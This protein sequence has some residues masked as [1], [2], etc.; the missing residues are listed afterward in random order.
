VSNSEDQNINNFGGGDS[1]SAGGSI[2]SGGGADF[3]TEPGASGGFKTEY[4]NIAPNETLGMD[5]VNATFKRFNDPSK[6]RFIKSSFEVIKGHE[7]LDLIDLSTFFHPLQSFSDIEKQTMV[8]GSMT[9]V[10][11]SPSSFGNT[12]GEVSL[13]IARAYYLPESELDERVLFWDYLG[14]QRNIM[15]KFMVLTGAVK[16]GYVWKGWDVDP[17]LTYN[18]AEPANNGLGGLI[19]SN[20]TPHNVKL[21]VIIAN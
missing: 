19:F 16:D 12:K 6:L 13:I 8:I 17:F 1:S 11:M 5:V 15:G 7:T 18:H 21:V 4:K 2:L 3:T 9:S 14:S 10:N 20:P